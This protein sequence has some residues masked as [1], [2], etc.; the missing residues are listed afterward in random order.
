MMKISADIVRKSPLIVNGSLQKLVKLTF[1]N[2]YYGN[3]M[4]FPR[5]LIYIAQRSKHKWQLSFVS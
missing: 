5:L 2:V 3:F 1:S 4:S